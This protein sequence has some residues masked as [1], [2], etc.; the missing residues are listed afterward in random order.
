MTKNIRKTL[1]ICPPSMKQTAIE[2]ESNNVVFE[3]TKIMSTKELKE[4][5]FFSANIKTL[6]YICENFNLPISFAKKIIPFLYY[7]NE[8]ENYSHPKLNY[9]KKIKLELVNNNLL[10]ENKLFLTFLKNCYVS[11]RYFDNMNKEDLFLFNEVSKYTSVNNESIATLE[12]KNIHQIYEFDTLND[13]CVFLFDNFASLIDKGE[14]INKII[15]LNPTPGSIFTL[16][17]FSKLYNIPLNLNKKIKLSHTL[18][19]KDFI[20]LLENNSIEDS[21]REIYDKYN[22]HSEGLRLYNKILDI[23]NNFSML[24]NYDQYKTYIINELENATIREDKTTNA[25]QVKDIESYTYKDNDIVFVM[26]AN[27]GVLNKIYKNDDFLSDELKKVINMPTSEEKNEEEKT[28][29]LNKLK[30]LNF[31]TITYHL[32]TP[33]EE[34]Y[35][36]FLNDLVEKDNI[37][38]NAKID[39]KYSYSLNKDLY[40]LINKK[41]LKH[42]DDEFNYLSK[43][44]DKYIS[45]YNPSFS[46]IDTNKIRELYL[47][48]KNGLRLSYTNMNTYYQCPFRF[49]LDNI[50]YLNS[51]EDSLATQIGVIFHEVLSKMYYDNFNFEEEFNSSINKFDFQAKELFLLEKL[52]E[53]LRLVIEFNKDHYNNTLFKNNLLEKEIIID[54]D[55]KNDVSLSFKGIIDKAMWYEEENKKYL[56]IIDYKTG[57]AEINLENINNGVGMQLPTYLYLASKS[58][59]FKG[60]EF[61]GFYL[62]QI[63]ANELSSDSKKT[64]EEIRKE[65]LKLIGYSNEN[66]TILSKFDPSFMSSSYIKS[67]AVK[68]NGDFYSYT[69][70]KNNEQINELIKIV[71]EKIS[72]AFNNIL[73]AD[74]AI[75]PYINSKNEEEG[76]KYC[77]YIDICYKQYIKEVRDNGKCKMDEEA[78]SSN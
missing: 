69:K 48:K 63:L 3:N 18:I 58:D 29:I 13:E 37:I 28:S 53:E 30:K 20:N 72:N 4:N 15:L 60:F 23:I 33:F 19:V 34:A 77:K 47:N 54:Y 40:Q 14:N 9:L 26:N 25:I 6:I 68:K 41:T 22:D 67:M 8:K 52:K 32:N 76:C 31:P 44:L 38:K 46:K 59:L 1:I 75:K 5:L 71:D 7:I 42:F 50:L 49:Y 36:S 70:T 43:N 66:K 73:N 65:R 39:N 27:Y 56:A 78:T 35:P 45:E 21:L 55:K 16:D 12:F 74:F 10:I 11:F 64:R 57:K 61:A 51:F 17:R 2:N 62:Q 24:G